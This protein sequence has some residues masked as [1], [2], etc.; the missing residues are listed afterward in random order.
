MD[1][2]LIE[3]VPSLSLTVTAAV[4]LYMLS[5]SLIHWILG[6]F[7]SCCS[8]CCCCCCSL[9]LLMLLLLNLRLSYRHNNWETR[10]CPCRDFGRC[11]EAQLNVFVRT[12]ARTWSYNHWA[13]RTDSSMCL[14]CNGQRK[15]ITTQTE[16]QQMVNGKW[17]M[18][19]CEK[20]TTVENLVVG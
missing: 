11:P 2:D 5:L 15:I 14:S 12:S 9:S 13:N 4:P 10:T 17:Q 7:R 18:V 3:L 20:S 16:T 1:E 8:C 19:K 6:L